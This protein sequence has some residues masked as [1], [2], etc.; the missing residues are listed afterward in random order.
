M[1]NA[2]PAWLEARPTGKVIP[3]VNTRKQEL[4]FGQLE[5]VD[6]ER[7]VV[8]LVQQQ[9]TI[10][11]CALYGE[12][13][14]P[15]EGIDILAQRRD[16]E[17]A[18]CYQCK[19]VDTLS[20]ALIRK[21]FDKFLENS[22]AEKASQFVLCVSLPTIRKELQSEI[23]KQA[24]KLRSKGIEFSMWDASPAGQLVGVLKDCP[25]LVDD[26]FGR[27]WV[28]LFNGKEAASEL[29]GRLDHS[30][31]IKLKRRLHDL[32]GVIFEQHDPGPPTPRH[33]KKASYA[34]RYVHIDVIQQGSRHQS[35]QVSLKKPKDLSTDAADEQWPNDYAQRTLPSASAEEN[36]SDR[37]EH[38]SEQLR[39]LAR[40]DEINLPAFEW[41]ADKRKCLVLGEPGSGKSAL[42]RFLAL[43]FVN[44]E[45]KD[46]PALL[47]D[48]LRKFPIWMSFARFSAAIRDKPQT[49]VED[50]FDQWLHENSHDDITPLF[51]RALKQSDV[52]LFLDGLDEAV[53]TQHG[54]EAFDR[55]VTFVQSVDAIVVCT[56][57]PFAQ[58]NFAIPAD[59]HA[60]SIAPLRDTHIQS[61]AKRWFNATEFGSLEETPGEITEKQADRR[62]EQFLRA[63][64]GNQRTNKL[65][66]NP[67][68]CLAMIRLHQSSHQLPV[69]RAK[70]FNDIIDLLLSRHP[71]ARA[72]AGMKEAPVNSLKI[73]GGDL[74]EILVQLASEFQNSGDIDAHPVERCHQVCVRFLEDDIGGLGL[75]KAE[76]KQ[77][78]RRAI[79]HLTEDFGLL[80]SK[81]ADVLGFVHLSIQEHL[82]AE[83]ITRRTEDHQLAWLSEV[84]QKQEWRECVTDWFAIQGERRNSQLTGLAAERIH[85]LGDEGE[86]QRLQSL[87]LLTELA[88]ADIELPVRISREVIEEAGRA[89][90]TS[91]HSSHRTK[92]AKSITIGALSP[93]L[94]DACASWVTQWLPGRP[95]SQ[96]ASLLRSFDSWGP[97]ED[98]RATLH[99]AIEDE[100]HDCRTAA[101][102]TLLS[103]FAT[104]PCLGETL[105]DLAESN[106]KPEIR[107]LALRTLTK[108]TPW[109]DRATQACN[110]NAQSLSPEMAY[111]ICAARVECGKHGEHDLNTLLD[112]W[113]NHSLTFELER[114]FTQTL[115]SGWPRHRG[116]TKSFETF[117]ATEQATLYFKTPLVYLTRCYPG[118]DHV[119][120]LLAKQFD[121]HGLHLSFLS[122]LWKFLIEGFRGNRILQGALRRALDDYKEKYSS[123][124]WHPQT[125]PAY[126]VIGDSAARDQLIKAYI[127]NNIR[128]WDRYWIAHTLI[129]HW[130]HDKKA[131]ASLQRWAAADASLA[132]PLASWADKFWEDPA[133]QRKKLS[134][135]IEQASPEIVTLAMHAIL[136]SFPDEQ[137]RLLVQERNSDERIWYY[138]RVRTQA[139]LARYF[140]EHPLSVKTVEHALS[141][142]DG[143]NLSDLSIGY[144]N[145]QRFR[146]ELLNASLTVPEDVRNS[147]A[148]TLRDYAFD[149][150]TVGKLTPFP[151]AEGSPSVRTTVLVGRAR[152]AKVADDSSAQ[153][154][155]EMLAPEITSLG[156]FH[157]MRRLT[158]LAG[159]IELGQPQLGDTTFVLDTPL[160]SLEDYS[161]AIAVVVANWHLLQPLLEE[162]GF[163]TELPVEKLIAAGYGSVL[164]QARGGQA[165]L[166]LYLQ[167]LD[168]ADL[169]EHQLH[170]LARRFPG[171]RLLR[172]ALL[173]ALIRPSGWGAVRSVNKYKVAQLLTDHFG[174]DSET[175]VSLASHFENNPVA[176]RSLGPGTVSILKLGWPKDVQELVLHE[177]NMDRAHWT[178]SDHLLNA[179]AEG[180]GEKAERIAESIVFKSAR[181]W[182]YWGYHKQALR[183]WSDQQLAQPVIQ[184]WSESTNGTLAVTGLAFSSPST[185]GEPCQ[186]EKLIDRFNGELS[187]NAMPP[188]EGFDATTGLFVGLSVQVGGTLCRIQ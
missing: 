62:A 107:A 187:S 103:V 75:P 102:Q 42:L 147:V 83:R 77:L 23:Y 16:A 169:N 57:R 162:A 119:A 136:E 145:H 116:V 117:L 53:D 27:S 6:F 144:E 92:I 131:I 149:P 174:A 69:A 54:R 93:K 128:G 8:R 171:S 5:W 48:A 100:D 20:P 55:V 158:A 150:H 180:D 11:D 22:W 24:Q 120:T 37:Q 168:I 2:I 151:L 65:S 111:S 47:P 141:E 188:R 175:F 79:G 115:C 73:S 50:Y 43:Y 138:H 176:L 51:E 106:A 179:T 137:S 139:L 170:E 98:L 108:R 76:A 156:Q 28:E 4:P 183:L 66:R 10:I 84:W 78:A 87:E 13:G 71:A 44:D 88:C 40:T 94:G 101:A 32:Y 96:R 121:R 153:A 70:L 52:I 46:N 143:P 166:D 135:L 34:R 39:G 82:A 126:A 86:W 109:H 104:W 60:A 97:S 140:P 85:E 67:L 56:S 186:V 31:A 127:G 114:E 80:V 26:F 9:N 18:A 74:R 177:S 129:T 146:G 29:E 132:A 25:K 118:D 152:L 184:R 63:A 91:P 157:E 15:Q 163:D 33:G 181:N 124:I 17:K 59:W 133:F 90:G 167:S 58:S 81:G 89:V 30:D 19:K 45:S 122:I 164:S 99:C 178:D 173:A 7:L 112:I 159:L 105:Q 3:P 172:D 38:G 148:S 142:I 123:I 72:Q 61:L 36:S 35:H 134:L 41:L 161:S 64:K 165:A 130:P 12:P 68:L 49:N 125:I 154:L 185:M 14:Q 95:A 182:R 155:A 113:S 160:I 1:P 110:V 21:T